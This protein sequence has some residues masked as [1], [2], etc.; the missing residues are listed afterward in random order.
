MSDFFHSCT[1]SAL[2]RVQGEDT[3]DYLQS[4]LTI[5]MSKLDAGRFRFGLRLDKKGKVMAGIY[6]IPLDSETVLLLSRGSSP[7][8]LITL[9][10]ENLVADD[11]ELFDESSRFRLITIQGNSAEKIFKQLNIEPPSK[12]KVSQSGGILSFLDSRLPDTTYSILAPENESINSLK[13]FNSMDWNWLDEKRVQL[14]L[15]NIPQEIG[16]EELPQEAQLQKDCVDFEKGCYLGQEV[17]ARIQ[18]MGKVRR[19]LIPVKIFAS[20]C[21]SIPSPLLKDGKK[22]GM[23]KSCVGHSNNFI[24]L[25]ILHE[26]TISALEKNQIE[27]QGFDA[28]ISTI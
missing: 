14:G 25:A 11:V 9:F 13:E 22:V 24:G 2:I 19:K 16:P 10:G 8:Q 26:N 4:Q 1:P 15:A 18:A 17:M 28:R 23:L 5:D 6:V 12:D 7:P 3:F 27:V 20:N 21:P